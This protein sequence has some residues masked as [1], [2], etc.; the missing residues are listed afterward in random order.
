MS[1]DIS[2]ILYWLLCSGSLVSADDTGKETVE[3][4]VG[5]DTDSEGGTVSD[6]VSGICVEKYGTD[7]KNVT[8]AGTKYFMVDGLLYRYLF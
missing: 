4:G 1:V 3:A 6:T 7:S 2:E 8:S 5:N